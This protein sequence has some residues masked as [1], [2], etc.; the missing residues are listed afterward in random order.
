MG[1]GSE[2]TGA[3]KP[4]PFVKHPNADAEVMETQTKPLIYSTILPSRGSASNAYFY[5]VRF[6]N[7]ANT[8][9]NFYHPMHNKNIKVEKFN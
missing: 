2:G 9:L 7:V 8:P 1:V 4:P 3:P 5:G 6:Y